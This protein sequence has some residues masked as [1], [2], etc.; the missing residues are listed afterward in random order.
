[1]A[2]RQIS[3]HRLAH[4]LVNGRHEAPARAVDPIRDHA[5]G[6]VAA[7]RAMNRQP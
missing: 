3:Q 2:A 6:Y 1:M 4:E 7:A 5:H